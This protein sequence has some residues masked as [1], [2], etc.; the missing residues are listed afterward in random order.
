MYCVHSTLHSVLHLLCKVYTVHVSLCYTCYSRCTQYMSVCVTPVIQSVH[1]TCQFVLHLLFKVY[2]VHVSLCYTCYSKCTQYMSVCVTP[3]IQSVHSTCQFVLHLLFKVYRLCFVFQNLKLD[4]DLQSER[5]SRLE[6]E[7]EELSNTRRDDHE[8]SVLLCVYFRRVFL[9]VLMVD[10][11]LN[12]F[13]TMHHFLCESF[14]VSHIL[15][16]R[17]FTHCTF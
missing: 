15:V 2:T 3:V 12:I 8:V 5:V 13:S 1:S 7:L 16:S 6:K 14:T 4:Y 10:F 9:Q 17:P 11:D